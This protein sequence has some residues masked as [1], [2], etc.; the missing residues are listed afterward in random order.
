MSETAQEHRDEAPAS[1]LAEPADADPKKAA[2]AAAIARA[3]AKKPPRLEGDD[4]VSET[5]REHRDEAPPAPVQAEPA[6]DADPKKAAVAAAIAR[7]KARKSRP[8]CGDDAVSETA[9]EHGTRGPTRIDL[10]EP[11]DADPKKAAIAAAVARAKARKLAPRLRPLP[12]PLRPTRATDPC[13]ISRVRPFCPQPQADPDHDGA[14]DPG[15][16]AGFGP[17]PGSSAGDPDPDPAGPGHG[18]GL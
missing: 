6:A 17:R 15:L 18:T 16:P 12:L 1:T 5:P 8:G 14:G 3:K 13:S 11:A 9:Q 7:A 4:A 10:A 2:V